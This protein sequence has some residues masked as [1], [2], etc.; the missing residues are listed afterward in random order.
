MLPPTERHLLQGAGASTKLNF[1]K[2]FKFC[3]CHLCKSWY[4]C[5]WSLLPGMSLSCSVRPLSQCPRVHAP[6]C[7]SSITAWDFSVQVGDWIRAQVHP[8]SSSRWDFVL[9][10]SWTCYQNKETL[11]LFRQVTC[12]RLIKSQITIALS[13]SCL[14]ITPLFLILHLELFKFSRF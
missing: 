13:L 12:H 5:A 1:K 10:A 6:S 2:L 14:H 4:F 8:A 3:T 11:F 7:K 9:H